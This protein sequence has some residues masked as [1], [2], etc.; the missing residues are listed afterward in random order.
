MNHA[1]RGVAALALCW[2][3]AVSAAR[4]ESIISGLS[5]SSYITGPKITDKD[6]RGKVVLIE[7]WGLNCPP[8]RASL[9]HMQEL[10][11]KYGARGNFM[12]LGS[13]C[14]SRDDAKILALLK[15]AKVTYPVYQFLRVEGMPSFSGIPHAAIIDH[16]GKFVTSGHI[17][18]VLEALPKIIQAAPV[19]IAGSLLG[20]AIVTFNKGVEQRLI[21][22]LNIE[23]TLAQLKEKAKADSEAGREA[24]DIVKQC[25]SWLSEREK[26]IRE[27]LTNEPSQALDSMLRYGRTCPSRAGVFAADVARL[28]SQPEIKK[29]LA[30]RSDFQKMEAA[31]PKAKG[32]VKT[33]VQ[34]A[35]FKKKY[36]APL[37][38]SADAAVKAE[39]KALTAR[40]DALVTEWH[41]QAQ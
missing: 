29:L 8:C 15:E 27:Q 21:F 13:H 12:L 30:F 19:P 39:A 38:D 36:Y 22:G 7:F 40:L 9:P 37:C 20:S 1:V 23:P 14:Q 5:D 35:A 24:A 3:A 26:L 4:A 31:K 16:T 6:L 32:A 41:A 25:E 28:N 11:Q 10:Y 2:M 17:S 33:A 18:E 34:Q